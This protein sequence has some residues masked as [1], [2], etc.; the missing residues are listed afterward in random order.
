MRQNAIYIRSYRD[1]SSDLAWH[2]FKQS[3]FFKLKT[4]YI[5]IAGQITGW[6]AIYEIT[7]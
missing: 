3:N 5:C 4:K 2:T 1:K 7:D 6:W